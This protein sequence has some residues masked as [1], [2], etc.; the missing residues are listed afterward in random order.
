MTD[1]MITS[2]MHRTLTLSSTVLQSTTFSPLL[3]ENDNNNDLL[4]KARDCAYST[5]TTAQEASQYLL[6]VLELQTYCRSENVLSTGYSDLCQNVDDIAEIVAQLRS[7]IG[8]SSS[9]T[10]YYGTSTTITTPL[11]P[12]NVPFLV[13]L[14][15]VITFYYYTTVLPNQWSTPIVPFTTE[16]WIYAM[17][18]GYMNLM[19]AHYI[20]NG[21]I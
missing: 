12:G 5:A 10:E 8:S 6:R 13:G 9:A 18:G 11:L 19:M 3:P 21:G 14:F 20:R 15:L 4:M 2:P 17:K 1:R 16:E 7:K